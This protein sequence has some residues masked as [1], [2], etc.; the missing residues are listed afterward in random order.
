MVFPSAKA[1]LMILSFV[2][3]ASV[4]FFGTPLTLHALIGVCVTCWIWALLV[5]YGIVQQQIA[6]ELEGTSAS[7]QAPVTSTPCQHEIPLEGCFDSCMGDACRA[8]SSST[9]ASSDEPD[10]VEIGA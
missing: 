4:V 9:Q 7:K 1:S 2:T 8:D 6:A 5:C 3:G 10:D